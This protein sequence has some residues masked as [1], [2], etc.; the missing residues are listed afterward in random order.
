[1]TGPALRSI[2]KKYD[3]LTITKFLRGEQTEIV[4]EDYDYKC[5]NFPQLTDEDISNIL[6]YTDN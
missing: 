2:S 3:S 6:A 5:V 1:M 4:N